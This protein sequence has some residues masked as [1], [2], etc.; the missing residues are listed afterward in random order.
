MGSDSRKTKAQLIDELALAKQRIIALE[1]TPANHD[2]TK[3]NRITAE[4]RKLE[5]QQSTILGK[6]ND[7]IIVLQDGLIK[8]AN[9]K[10]A[11]ITGLSLEDAPGK[12][13]ID[14]IAPQCRALVMERY[15]KRLA[16][17]EIPAKY[18]MGL[19]NKNGSVIPVEVN[20]G[21][22]E[23]DG[24]PAT[25]SMV[26]DISEHKAI[27]E[28]LKDSETR[29]RRLFETA[30]DAIL[31][32]NGDTGQI[33]DANPF[34]EDLL[35]L[36]LE[37]LIGKNLWEIG[38]FKDTLA[39]K[40][41]YRELHECGYKR[42]DNLP[43][44]A[45]DGRIISVEVVANAYQVDH[46]W[47]IQ[48]N[49]RDM[50]VADLAVKTLREVKQDLEIAQRL[51]GIGN[52]KWVIATNTVTWSEELYRIN[53][54]NSN[55]PVPPFAE[56]SRFYTPE[57]WLQLNALV[58]KAVN[59]GEP[60]GCEL[61]QIRT[62]GTKITTFSRGEADFDAGG[63]VIGLHGT[64][65]DITERKQVEEA[66]R[67][68][69][70]ELLESQ[71]IAGLGTYM[72]DIPAGNFTA[73]KVLEELF[74]IDKAYPHTVEGWL[75]L[76]HPE[77]RSMMLDY[78][79]NEVLGRKQSFDKEYR[80]VR[81]RDKTT[82]WL[83]GLGELDFD[84][85]G[86]PLRMHGAIQDITE[87]KNAERKLFLESERHRIIL[88]TAMDGVWRVNL[89][90]QLL[91]V[92]YS[93]CNMSGYS[94]PELLT[95]NISDLETIESAAATTAHIHKVITEG[96]DRFVSR[97][98][99]KDGSVFDV[100][101]SAKYQPEEGGTMVV[102]MHDVTEHNKLLEQL[103]AQDR[104]A[105]IGQLV[106]G[107]A[108]ELN[109]PLTSVIGFSELLLQRELPD[110]VKE[111]LKI[112]NEEARRTSLIVKH[113]LLFAR[114]QPQEKRAVDINETIQTVLRV[115]SHE[116]S[117]NNITVNTHLAPDLPQIMGNG[118]QLQQVFFN[119]VVNAEQVMIEARNKG[120]LTITTERVDNIVKARFT[121]DGPGIS[122][123][124]MKRL[125]SPFFTTKGVGKGTGLGLSICHGIITEH[126][127]KVYT[128]SELG[129]GATFI[130]ELPAP[131][132]QD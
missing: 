6:S 132:P 27:E 115:R 56:L 87:R 100:E 77:D 104:L 54:W 99:R 98:R 35:G 84:I 62:D 8:F 71:R 44:V 116:Q 28:K 126:G 105:S 113:L 33:I 17:E 58:A 30:Q 74:G 13:F 82:R 42:W 12:P 114:Q 109:N 108:H 14:Y 63:K 95:M 79:Q 59:T 75:G 117:T 53:G 68:H 67:Q 119:V 64:V 81:N 127:G 78:F 97:H 55:L 80:I 76:I 2:L 4:L 110:D 72:L 48:C 47:V 124:N 39:S 83:H 92:N 107:V 20:A 91:E 18:E 65:Q 102:F 36:S 11:E 24:K 22:I 41:S 106:S 60:Y 3:G 96:E 46:T 70:R 128:E 66:L 32:L 40:I 1:A 61:D 43:L 85:N 93:Y 15:R 9:S 120:T 52:W 103:V 5:K 34:I 31:I 50:T 69:E 89:Q 19:L 94:E 73:S 111:D 112:V 25:L 123:E 121:D 90:G 122:P 118:S 7:A 129:K 101:I 51:T 38:E 45:K 23:W 131:P 130:I 88:K 21:L 57:S 49:I 125:F 10:V 37:E 26:R 29:Y 86:H 16:G